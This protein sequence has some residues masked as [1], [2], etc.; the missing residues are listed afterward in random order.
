MPFLQHYG[1][2]PQDVEKRQFMFLNE[3]TLFEKNVDWYAPE[4]GRLWRYNLHYFDYFRTDRSCIS[5]TAIE[6]MIHWI[7]NNPTGTADAWDPFPTSLRAVNWMK[8][9]DGRDV[10]TTY[11]DEIV[12]SLYGQMT[13]L[14]KNLEY[15]LLANHLLKN[16]KALVFAGLFFGDKNGERWLSKGLQLLN[17]EHAEQILPDG[18]HF[19]RSPMYHAM[20]LEDC[21]DLLNA[22][23][24]S[25]RAEFD[26]TRNRLIAI[27]EKMSHFLAAMCHPDGEIALFNDAALGIEALP[28][29]LIAYYERLTGSSL[30]RPNNR[31]VSLPAS[32]YFIMSPARG[33]RLFVDCG[34]IGPDYQTGHS[35]CDTLSIELSLKGKRVIVDSGCY[36]YEDGPI[37]QYNRGNEGHNTITID[38]ENQS[39]VWGAHRCARRARPIYAKLGRQPDGAFLFEGAHDGYRRLKGSPIH[40]RRIKWLDDII[41][42]EDNI[43][44]NN[45]HTIESRLHIHPSFVVD[46]HNGEA[47]IRDEK[48]SLA[49]ITTK[50]NEHIEKTE[51]WYC[52]EFGI[53]QN[54]TVLRV[55]R[56][57]TPLPYKGGWLIKIAG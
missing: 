31:C 57:K 33:D 37:R 36:G 49:R 30:Q 13:F 20:V 22:M 1:C 39:E 15:H 47:D 55:L 23:D 6:L 4:K 29:D 32:G 19:E 26:N 56:E 42:V 28:S 27:T 34:P 18:G 50:G 7:H 41:H 2:T 10:K 46:L 43:E 25:G 5:E 44:G 51:G 17:R 40:H 12:A 24:G 35:H 8:F 38:G 11:A 16:I 14:E 54:C 21:L 3:T 45:I 48:G 53:K 9:L 52:P